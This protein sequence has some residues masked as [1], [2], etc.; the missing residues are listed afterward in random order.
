[1]SWSSCNCSAARVPPPG[2]GVDIQTWWSFIS[3]PC[4]TTQTHL[5]MFQTDFLLQSN[6]FQTLCTL[7]SSNITNSLQQCCFVYTVACVQLNMSCQVWCNCV[8][9][10]IA[11]TVDRPPGETAAPAPADPGIPWRGWPS[12]GQHRESSTICYVSDEECFL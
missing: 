3:L 5:K 11:E 9:D 1:M 2:P 12:Q 6:I 4:I 7:Q 10:D 8:D